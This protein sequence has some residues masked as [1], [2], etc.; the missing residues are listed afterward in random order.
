ML[1][2]STIKSYLLHQKRNCQFYQ[3]NEPKTISALENDKHKSKVYR[4]LLNLVRFAQ[5]RSVFAFFQKSFFWWGE[6][7]PD[8]TE[9][10]QLLPRRHLTLHHNSKDSLG[11]C[12]PNTNDVVINHINHVRH[13]QVPINKQKLGRL[14]G[15]CRWR[16]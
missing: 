2:N 9:A 8:V 6:H 4:K 5:M 15:E 3:Q 10:L 1:Y 14:Q 12:R 11:Y 16:G 13:P 7:P